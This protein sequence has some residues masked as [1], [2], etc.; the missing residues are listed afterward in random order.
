MI[1]YFI[2]MIALGFLTIASIQDVMYGFVSDKITLWF[3]R[4]IMLLS[5]VLTVYYSDMNVFIST[6]KSLTIFFIPSLL[7]F[8]L[9]LCGGADIIVISG[10]GETLGLI[11]AL[12]FKWRFTWIPPWLWFLFFV[13][14]IGVWL[15]AFS[16]GKSIISRIRFVPT[17][18]AAFI[19]T[20]L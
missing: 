3:L 2:V 11:D 17:L 6:A 1:E 18:T 10:I 16:G 19:L 15:L 4:T 12:G 13:F 14:V 8:L 9:K 7:F 20:L 5:L